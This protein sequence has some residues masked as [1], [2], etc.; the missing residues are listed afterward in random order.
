MPLDF[1][2]DMN[3]AM[4][5]AIQHYPYSSEYYIGQSSSET[6]LLIGLSNCTIECYP[7]VKFDM[8]LFV[9]WAI[10]MAI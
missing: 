6:L 5:V 8:L 1:D 2:D 10:P 3:M 9:V 4:D 7:F